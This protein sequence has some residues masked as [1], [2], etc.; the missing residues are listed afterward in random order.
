MHVLK[1][2][3]AA[4][5]KV[6]LPFR[7]HDDDPRRRAIARI[8][9]MRRVELE[10]NPTRP[11]YM[12]VMKTG[13]RRALARK[14]A[15]LALAVTSLAATAAL[16]AGGPAHASAAAT[17]TAASSSAICTAPAKY[18]AL[19]TRL[20]KDIAAAIRGRS[21]S[22][23][24]RVEDVRTG[25]ECR[26]NE[27]RRSHSASVV[28]AT[29]LAALLYWRQRTHTSLTSTEKRE[30]TLMIEYSDNDAAT[31]LWNDVGHARLNQFIKA[32]TMT[33]TE[34][35]SGGYW[36]LSEITARDELQLTRL[37]TEHNSVL[38]DASRAYELNLMNHVVSYERW[39]VPAGAPSGLTVYVKNGWLNDPVLWVINSIGAI[40]GHGR[41][42]KMAI[43]TYD[44][45]NEQ[46]GINTVQAIAEAANRDL[47]AGLPAA[48]TLLAPTVL[49]RSLQGQPDEA[50]PPGAH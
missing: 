31:Y 23:A 19:A 8:Y 4:D 2:I 44:N 9:Q 18:G 20:S 7:R 46:Y 50:L 21:G 13:L 37:L 48:G 14:P 10:K 6:T 33:E 12:S 3:P 35:N 1:S 42:Y 38:T 27:G 34:L 24:I 39:G 11:I 5:V 30:A 40:E 41:N 28:K 26:Y 16:T 45:P 49:P 15:A 43:L 25:V 17:A 22:I 32:A 47:N 29:I 36:G